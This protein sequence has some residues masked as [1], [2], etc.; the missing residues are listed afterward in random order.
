MPVLVE[1]DILEFNVAIDDAERVQ[2]LEGAHDLGRVESH[3][4]LLEVLAL[5]EMREELTTANI[6]EDEM[7]FGVRLERVVE[8][9]EKRRLAHRGKHLPFGSDVLGCFCFLDD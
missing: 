9:D 2:V 4:V 8:C 1:Q 7:Q 5:E 6:L 3:L